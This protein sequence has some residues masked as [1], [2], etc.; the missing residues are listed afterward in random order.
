MGKKK[1]DL[2]MLDT[3]TKAETGA[4]CEIDHPVERTK[5]GIKITLAGADSDVYQNHLNAVA[6]KRV[7]RMKPGQFVPPTAEETTETSLA[8]LAAC[9]L[10]WEGMFLDGQE[11]PCNSENAIMIYRRFPWIREQ[12]DA[13]IGDRANFLS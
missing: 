10:S 5:L 12:V 3:K 9:T 11:V 4:V 2:G 13:F 8:L 1:F 6:N 7:K